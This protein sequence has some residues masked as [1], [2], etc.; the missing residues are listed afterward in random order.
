MFMRPRRADIFGAAINSQLLLGQMLLDNS[1]QVEGL[2][3]L[4]P[5]PPTNLVNL[6]QG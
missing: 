1:I 2:L 6:V 5:Q 4:D 3:A